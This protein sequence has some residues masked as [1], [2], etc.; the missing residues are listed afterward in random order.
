VARA[1]RSRIDRLEAPDACASSAERLDR[2]ALSARSMICATIKDRLAQAGIDPAGVPALWLT[3][4][5]DPCGAPS[6]T[7]SR[8]RGREGSGEDE[9]SEKPEELAAFGE[10]GLAGEF[11]E[12]IGDMV[13]HFEDGHDPDFANASLAE[14]F[15][16]CLAQPPQSSED[17]A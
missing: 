6:L 14:L 4:P 16:W 17:P 13:C 9:A 15:A 5:S 2:F 3:S 1:R 10:D 11:R 12:K 7:Q 8:L